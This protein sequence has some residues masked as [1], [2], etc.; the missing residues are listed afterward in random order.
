MSA[1]K[2]CFGQISV[3]VSRVVDQSKLLRRCCRSAKPKIVSSSYP[4]GLLHRVQLLDISRGDLA[5]EHKN[6]VDVRMPTV[7]TIGNFRSP[8]DAANPEIFPTFPNRPTLRHSLPK[9]CSR[10]QQVFKRI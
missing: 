8:N 3:D 10:C 5:I 4:C 6:R 9:F 2:S 1:V 7:L